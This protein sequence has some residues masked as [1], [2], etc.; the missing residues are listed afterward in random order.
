MKWSK[1]LLLTE[2]KDHLSK[3]LWSLLF[4]I[5]DIAMKHHQNKLFSFPVKEFGS[6][7]NQESN[8]A[9]SKSN[10][11]SQLNFYNSGLLYSNSMMSF[12]DTI[13]L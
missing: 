6:Y 5:K 2:I 9:K 10:L 13:E 11:Y 12:K 7:H 1:T 3:T 8:P 4:Q